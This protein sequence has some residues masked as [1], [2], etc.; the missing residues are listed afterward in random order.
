[1]VGFRSFTKHDDFQQQKMLTEKTHEIRSDI[2]RKYE[3]LVCVGHQ[4]LSDFP[5]SPK[6]SDVCSV[7]NN[8]FNSIFDHCCY[9]KL[10]SC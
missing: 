10:F 5:K 3:E 4:S 1:M 7:L 8:T 6:H 9:L 2:Y